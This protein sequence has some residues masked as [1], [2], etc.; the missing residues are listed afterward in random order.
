MRLQERRDVSLGAPRRFERF[1][2]KRSGYRARLVSRSVIARDLH[3]PVAS[4]HNRSMA[5]SMSCESILLWG[6]AER[7]FFAVRMGD[8]A[9]RHDTWQAGDLHVRSGISSDSFRLWRAPGYGRV[10]HDRPHVSIA[11]VCAKFF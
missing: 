6:I 2:F 9:E 8:Q 5:P 11:I 10:P 7:R 3:E 1:T 4:C